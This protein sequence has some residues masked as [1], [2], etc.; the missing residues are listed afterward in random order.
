M[1][2]RRRS[3]AEPVPDLAG[4]YAE[5]RPASGSCGKYVTQVARLRTDP[6]VHQTSWEAGGEWI[7]NRC[8]NVRHGE[9][10]AD[11]HLCT[12]GDT[13]WD[14][15]RPKSPGCSR[16]GLPGSGS[17]SRVL[18]MERCAHGQGGRRGGAVG[19]LA[20]GGCVATGGDRD[21]SAERSLGCRVYLGVRPGCRMHPV[22]SD[23]FAADADGLQFR[24]GEGP[25]LDA[26]RPAPADTR[27]ESTVVADLTAEAAA[28]SGVRPRRLW[29]SGLSW[30]SACPPT[31]RWGRSAGRPGIIG[32]GP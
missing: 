27:P 7:R 3:P 6:A 12:A 28:R 19:G 31:A 29:G 18:G 20:V 8:A 15:D 4:G 25:G 11:H 21:G 2:E 17:G 30:R 13:E 24:V 22:C 26:V 14:F 32:P 1:R 10:R 9:C 5:R 16:L 23:E